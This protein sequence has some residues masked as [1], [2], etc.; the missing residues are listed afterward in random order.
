[1]LLP[2]QI[3]LLNLTGRT[4]VSGRVP[5]RGCKEHLSHMLIDILI[6]DLEHPLHLRSR[7][8]SG[9]DFQLIFDGVSN[10]GAKTN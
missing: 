2:V 8:F 5:S 10:R 3:L 1:M 7:P 4:L 9:R 6:A